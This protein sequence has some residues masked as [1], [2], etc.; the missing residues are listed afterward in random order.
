MF[1]IDDVLKLAEGSIY[2]VLANNVLTVR[3]G[4]L[5]TGSRS[6]HILIPTRELTL[7][8]SHITV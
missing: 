3:S 8:R 6:P 2:V 4:V 7:E 5:L 1:L